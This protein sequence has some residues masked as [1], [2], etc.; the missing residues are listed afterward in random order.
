VDKVVGSV[1]RYEDFDRTFLPKTPHTL[2]RW[3]R[4]RALR[5]SGVLDTSV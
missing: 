4:L 3:K 1:D 2:E 5:P